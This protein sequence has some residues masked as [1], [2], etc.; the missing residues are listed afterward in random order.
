M[1]PISILNDWLTA[2]DGETFAIGRGLAVV[3]FLV[4]MVLAIG[5]TVAAGVATLRAEGHPDLGEWGMYLGGLGSY[6]GLVAGAV[7]AMVRGTSATEPKEDP[8]P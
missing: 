4:A 3:L 1:R 5:I 6:F 7:W 8:T 2:R